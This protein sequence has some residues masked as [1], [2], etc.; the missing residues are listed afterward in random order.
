MLRPRLQ[1][2]ARLR[3]SFGQAAAHDRRF[4]GEGRQQPGWTS[5]VENDEN[6][7]VRFASDQPAES[8]FQSQPGDQIIVTFAE[9][10]APRL[11]QD[12]RLRPGHL[13]EYAKPQGSAGDIHTIAQRIRTK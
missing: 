4:G 11:V 9:A 2:S 1:E 12:C 10:F 8:L 13:V 6:A 7:L 3:D 5:T